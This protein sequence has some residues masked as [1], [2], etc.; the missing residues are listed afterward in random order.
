M[1]ETPFTLVGQAD[2]VL[3]TPEQAAAAL[4]VAP[5]TMEKW[6]RNGRGPVF[7]KLGRTVRYRVGDLRAFIADAAVSSTAEAAVRGMT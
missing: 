5:A 7:L 3:V 1:T 6:R 4:T 2:D